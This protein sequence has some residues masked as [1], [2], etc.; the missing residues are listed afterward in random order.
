M[1]GITQKHCPHGINIA[2]TK[3]MPNLAIEGFFSN[4][5]NHD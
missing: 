3:K 5:I 4:I 1:P 2:V